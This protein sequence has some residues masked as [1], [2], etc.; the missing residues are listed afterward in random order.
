MAGGLSQLGRYNSPAELRQARIVDRGRF[1]KTLSGDDNKLFSSLHPD[2]QLAIGSYAIAHPD[3]DVH[4]FA[5][6]K[7]GNGKW[8]AS[9]PK[10]VVNI[11]VM[12]DNPMHAILAHE[13]GHH[14]ASHELGDQVDT[15]TR[16]DPITGR[17]GLTT[18]L[19]ANGKPMVQVDAEG[20]QTF[21]QNAQLE[22]YK[23]NYNAR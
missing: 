12:G 16:G 17:A 11:N 1:I 15:Y 10:G 18:Q 8:Q 23:A 4:F 21:V 13:I 20:N 5:D 6:K 3:L 7:G 22:K 19:D 14:I 2:Y 9:A